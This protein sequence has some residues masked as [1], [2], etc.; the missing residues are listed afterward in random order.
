MKRT[1]QT[2]SCIVHVVTLHIALTDILLV[3]FTHTLQCVD[4]SWTTLR[5]LVQLAKDFM[6]F[7]KKV[8]G[9]IKE[10]CGGWIY[11]IL[12]SQK[13]KSIVRN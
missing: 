1:Y 4:L 10:T 2:V 7:S 3:S 8:F 5:Q 12:F 9:K 13:H 6:N 11:A